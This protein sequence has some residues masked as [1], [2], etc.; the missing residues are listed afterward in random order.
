MAGFSQAQAYP[1][2][3]DSTNTG[4][5]ETSAVSGWHDVVL[6]FWQLE[7]DGEAGLSFDGCSAGDASKDATAEKTA[8]GN[9]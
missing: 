4:A 5:V 6:V 9:R 7:F 3:P 2:L 1:V 8:A